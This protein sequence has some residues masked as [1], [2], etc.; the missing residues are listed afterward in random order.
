MRVACPFCPNHRNHW[1]KLVWVASIGWVLP[2]LLAGLGYLIATLID[3]ASGLALT[4][5]LGVGAS[6][7]LVTWLVV[8]IYLAST[9]I[10]ATK[11]TDEEITFQR[12]ADGFVR[13]I[14]DRQEA[15]RAML[16]NA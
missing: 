11:I 6:L 14:R 4:I 12:V 2:F 13:V 3:P 16:S 10:T 7:G 8:V 9:R 5:G 1:R 15:D